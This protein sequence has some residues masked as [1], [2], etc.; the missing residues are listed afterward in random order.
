M[1]P[2]EGQLA[3][4]D[5]TLVSQTRRGD[6]HAYRTLTARHH[7]A[8]RLTASLLGA[9]A[10]LVRETYEV[11]HDCLL[12]HSE[13]AEAVRPFFL[14]VARH[15]HERPSPEASLVRDSSCPGVPFRDHVGERHAA[16]AAE[17]SWLPDAWQAALWHRFVE[18]DDDARIGAMLGI[19]PGKVGSLI[20]GALD[21]LR[22][23]LVARRR[24]RPVPP[25][26][27]GYG[28]RLE[29][30]GGH[31]VPRSVVRHAATCERCAV[32]LEDLAAVETDLAAVLAEHLLGAAGAGYLAARRP[33][34]VSTA[35]GG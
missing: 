12:R 19:V 10:S 23:D 35:T 17:V 27:M 22:R 34:V 2:F 31:V 33:G 4:T 8:V 32:L 18:G 5:A 25:Q 6:V 14:L 11:A 26:C 21:M 13:H 16:L 3:A 30:A 15:L 29:R 9:S 1:S 7:E 20:E 28:L 24:T